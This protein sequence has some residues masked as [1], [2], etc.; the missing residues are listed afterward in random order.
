MAPFSLVVV[1]VVHLVTVP[2]V[3][4]EGDP[5]VAIHI[6]GPLPFPDS[7]ERMKSQAGRVEV[8]DA[9]RGLEPSQNP[10]DLRQVVRVQ[11]S[12]IPS[13]KEPL[14]PAVLESDDHRRSVT[15]NGSRVN[16]TKTVI[17]STEASPLSAD[18]VRME[19]APRKSALLPFVHLSF[20]KSI[21]Y[22]GAG[23]GI[24]TRTV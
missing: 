7:F 14:Q 1:L 4:A 3:E 8:P 12:G 10:T 16:A 9:G 6:N 13:L 22:G 11:P 20:V 23:A 24:R 15:C 21:S 2:T 18:I 17:P 5:P 19:L